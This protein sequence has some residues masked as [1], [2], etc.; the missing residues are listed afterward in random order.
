MKAYF[1]FILVLL[2]TVGCNPEDDGPTVQQVQQNIN[3]GIVLPLKDRDYSFHNYGDYGV[4]DIPT[5]QKNLKAKIGLTGDLGVSPDDLIVK[6]ISD[7][8][9]EL[10][11]GHPNGNFE[12]TLTTSLSKGLHTISFEV[13]LVNN[14]ELLQK[15]TIVISNI[16]KLEATPQLGRFMRLNWTKYEGSDF[17]SYLVY[18]NNSQPLAEITDI[19]T[20]QFDYTQPHF[21]TEEIPYQIVVKTSNPN[22]Q[23]ETLGSNIVTKITG[24]FLSIPYYI[25]K[26]VKDPIRNKLYAICSP[27]D[28]SEEADKY[29]IIIINTDTFTIENHIL[30]TKRFTDISVVPDG[31]Y[32]YL[33]QRHV[34]FI[35][36]VN[37]NNYSYNGI[38]THTSGNGF[39]NIEAGNNNLL[40]ANVYNDNER[41]QMINATNGSYTESFNGFNLGEMRYNSS[42]DNLYYGNANSSGRLYKLNSSNIGTGTYLTLPQYP[43]FPSGV[44]YPYPVVTI[45]DNGNHIFWDEFQ[46]DTNLNVI[47]QFN[48]IHIHACSPS[49][50]YIS[51]LYKIYDYN[52]MNTIITYPNFGSNEYHD[53]DIYFTDENT[54]FTNK[55]YDP[56]DGSPSYSYIFRMKIN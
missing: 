9:G 7:I 16:I 42:N 19:N 31:Q 13:Y 56:N 26:M 2:I 24:D 35:T 8:D 44:S 6:W 14:P 21:A 37:L 17:V 12:S 47:R 27:K 34:D 43:E 22:W 23:Y 38:A 53:S 11:A 40:Y 46:L 45:S 20:L 33:T 55:T 30:T 18:R 36:K 1:Y 51:D 10:Y 49:N 5:N 32:M 15:D 3:V 54:I 39:N 25:K 28:L 52:T 48:D 50:Q 4:Y 41:F 29:G